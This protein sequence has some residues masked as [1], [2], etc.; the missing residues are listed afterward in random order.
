MD[1]VKPGP[2]KPIKHANI[3]FL[4]EFYARLKGAADRR[5]LSV[6]AYIRVAVLESVSRDEETFSRL[7]R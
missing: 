7:D 5:M 3:E 1:T 2:E 4:P 6:R